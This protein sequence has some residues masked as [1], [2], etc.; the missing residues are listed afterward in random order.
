MYYSYIYI[1][2]LISHF[3]FLNSVQ[4]NNDKKKLRRQYL[5]NLLIH[6]LSGSRQSVLSPWFSLRYWDGTD[7][8]ERSAVGDRSSPDMGEIRGVLG[9]SEIEYLLLLPRY[10]CIMYLGNFRG[11]SR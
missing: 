10:S 4:K 2:R 5:C 1:S 11:S 3:D 6:Q 7:L 9:I 8:T